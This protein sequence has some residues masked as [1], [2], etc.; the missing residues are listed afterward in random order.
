VRRVHR[1]IPARGTPANLQ[2]PLSAQKAVLKPPHSKR[3]R[4]GRISL[5]LRETSGE[6]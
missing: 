5:K 4:E 6:F 3:W 1:R 2:K